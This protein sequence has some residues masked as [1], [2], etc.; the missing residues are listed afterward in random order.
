MFGGGDISTF[1][2][3]NTS[4]SKVHLVDEIALCG[5]VYSRWM[6]FLEHFMKTLKGIMRQ[7]LSPEGSMAEGLSIQESLVPTEFLVKVDRTLPQMRRDEEDIR[8][9]SIMP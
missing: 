2:P 3:H 8:M 9:A 1:Y 7:N 5:I 6:F 4:T